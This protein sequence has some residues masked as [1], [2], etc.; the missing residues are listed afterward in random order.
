MSDVIQHVNTLVQHMV[1]AS[2]VRYTAVDFKDLLKEL[3][4]TATKATLDRI[5][6]AAMVDTRL[7]VQ[8]VTKTK[9]YISYRGIA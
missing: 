8:H 9:Y 3:W 2:Q 4:P 6:K 7:K 5:R 1:I